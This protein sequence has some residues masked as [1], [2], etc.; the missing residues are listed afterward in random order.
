VSRYLV[1]LLV[2]KIHQR[3]SKLRISTISRVDCLSLIGKHFIIPYRSSGVL[4]ATSRRRQTKE[5]VGRKSF[6]WN[7]RRQNHSNLA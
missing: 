3:S 1:G 4:V 7:L 2:E 6:L 5:V